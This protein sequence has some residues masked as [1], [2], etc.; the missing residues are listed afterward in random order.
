MQSQFG[1]NIKVTVWGGSHEPSIGVDIEGLPKGAHV[2]M[3]KLKDFL[4]RRAP[5]NSP[6]STKRKEP[7]TPIPVSVSL[8]CPHQTADPDMMTIYL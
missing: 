6:F 2:D 4:K 8:L 7:D 5:G 1:K 3:K